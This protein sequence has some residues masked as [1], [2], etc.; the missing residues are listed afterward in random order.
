MAEEYKLKGEKLSENNSKEE[1]YPFGNCNLL[2][3][4]EVTNVD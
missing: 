3:E 1:N 4:I 2:I